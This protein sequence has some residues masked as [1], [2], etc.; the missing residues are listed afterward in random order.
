MPF[1]RL[2]IVA[3]ALVALVSSR[4]AAQSRPIHVNIGGGPTFAFSDIGNRFS[5]GWGPAIGVAIDSGRNTAFQ[6][7]Y[8]WRWLDLKN[9]ADSQGARFSAS[10][11]THQ[12]DVNMI[13]NLTRPGSRLRVYVIGGPGA[14]YRSVNITQYVGSGVVC[15]PFWYLCGT[16]P[17]NEILGSRGSWDVGFNAGGGGGVDL[18]L[19]EFFIETR[20]HFIW[21]PEIEVPRG[22][23]GGAPIILKADGL[24]WPFTFGIRF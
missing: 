11:R 20:F 8:A 21:G 10:H 16:F 13:G 3:L 9:E 23:P 14:Y 1:R 24:Y 5:T 17:A 4:A 12:I 7:E 2:S 18:G 6:I 22:Q 15:D 19:A